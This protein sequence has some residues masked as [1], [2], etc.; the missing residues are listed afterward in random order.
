MPQGR[1]VVEGRDVRKHE[2]ALGTLVA[3]LRGGLARAFPL[4]ALHPVP[5]FLP[6]LALA[7]PLLRLD[8]VSLLLAVLLMHFRRQLGHRPH[9]LQPRVVRPETWLWGF[10]C[11]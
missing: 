11:L 3:F 2:V 5:L 10:N 8:L 6:L 4:L 7:P 1:V 9:V